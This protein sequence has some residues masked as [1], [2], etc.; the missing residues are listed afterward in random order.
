M[1]LQPGTKRRT[2]VEA[3]RLVIIADVNDPPFHCLRLRVRVVALAKNTFVPV[4]KRCRAR[5]VGDNAG[6]RTLA[7]RLIKV[8][9]NYDVTRFSHRRSEVSSRCSLKLVKTFQGYTKRHRVRV[10]NARGCEPSLR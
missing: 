9:V 2:E 5:F 10:E 7:R 1:A 8:T 6:P 4:R 3:Q